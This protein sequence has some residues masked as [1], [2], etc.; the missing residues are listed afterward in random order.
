MDWLTA[1]APTD[2]VSILALML[3]MVIGLMALGVPVA[4]AFLVADLV[5]ALLFLGGVAGL[6]QL[7]GN[8]V[9]S[10]TQV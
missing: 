3:G 4:F 9:S 6:G 5:G 7:V 8:A 2:W 1:L 10:V